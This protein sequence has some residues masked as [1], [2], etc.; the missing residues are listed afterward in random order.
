MR[1]IRL[2]V[3]VHEV[4]LSYSAPPHY[5]KVSAQ[6]RYVVRT[7]CGRSYSFSMAMYHEK[8]IN[9]DAVITCVRCLAGVDAE[10]R[11]LPMAFEG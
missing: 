1:G 9:N 2:I 3:M 7:R 5:T 11:A 8:H 4:V 6:P 10:G